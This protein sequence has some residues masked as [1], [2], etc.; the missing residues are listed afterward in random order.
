L[1]RC[2]STPIDRDS[3]ISGSILKRIAILATHGFEQSELP[4]DLEAFGAEII[5]EVREGRHSRRSAA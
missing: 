2:L 5:E 4:S 1:E 3:S